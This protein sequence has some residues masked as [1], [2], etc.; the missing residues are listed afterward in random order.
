[1]LHGCRSE[2][3][4]ASREAIDWSP[5]ADSIETLNGKEAKND[6]FLRGRLWREDA[7]SETES[8]R[9]PTLSMIAAAKRQVVTLKSSVGLTSQS[10]DNWKS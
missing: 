8:R 10:D 9:T 6:T 1:M 4:A 3:V 7:K 2:G 5:D